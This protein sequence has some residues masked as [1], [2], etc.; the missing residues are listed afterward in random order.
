V[1]NHG[2][3]PLTLRWFAHPFFPIHQLL[4]RFSEGAEMPDNPA[5][6]FTNDASLKRNPDYP[7]TKGFYQ[8][9]MMEWG[10]PLRVEQFHP[11]VG[12]VAVEC[13]FP[14]AKMPIWGNANTFSFEP[15]YETVVEPGKRT[16]WFMGYSF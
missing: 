8:P 12:T 7:W 10:K 11:V 14:L 6:G 16:S 3:A 2:D 13:G 15:Y 4:C 1:V 5:F 9:L